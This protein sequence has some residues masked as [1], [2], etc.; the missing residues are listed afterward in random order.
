MSCVNNNLINTELRNSKI[1]N[2]M[3]KAWIIEE[4]EKLPFMIQKQ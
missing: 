2:N 3:L 4:S 1:K